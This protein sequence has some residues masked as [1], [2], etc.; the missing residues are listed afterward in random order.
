MPEYTET[1]TWHEIT[2]RSLTDEEKAEYIERG[3]ADYEI[4]NFMYDYPMPSDGEEVLI[5]TWQG[6]YKDVCCVTVDGLNDKSRL[7]VYGDWDGVFAWAEMP[8]ASNS[9]LE[10]FPSANVA[11]VVHG[12]WEPIINEY[13]ELEGWI[14]KRCG[15]ETKQKS[16]YC[17]SCGSRMDGGSE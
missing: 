13:G 12:K 2:C 10:I 7:E 5:A 14:C 16:N 9:L 6:V 8:S 17:P 3:Y 11:P 1:I 15:T 4:P